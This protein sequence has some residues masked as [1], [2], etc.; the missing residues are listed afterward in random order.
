MKLPSLRA[1][2]LILIGIAFLAGFGTIVLTQ[3]PLA[4]TKVTLGT[5]ASGTLTPSLF[6]IG[7]VEARRAYNIGPTVAGRVARVL[8]DQGDRVHAGQLLAEMD[9]VDLAE[10]QTAGAAAAARA[11]QL[12]AAA[13]AA[14]AEA[15]S[16]A[17]LAQASAARYA[18]LHARNFISKDAAA[19]KN[20]E[21][22]AATAA[23]AATKAALAAAESEARR[24][25]ADLAGTGRN[26]AL[27]RLLA[28]VDGVA[29]ARLAEP[30]STLVA[31]Q[32][33]LQMI[34]PASLWLRT[35]I[36][37][38]RSGGLAVGL[39]AEIHLRSRPGQPL[40]GHVERIEINGD[41]VTEE[42]IAQVAMDSP[43]ADPALGEIAEITL[44]LPVLANVLNIPAAAIKVEGGKTGVWI[45]DGGRTAFRAVD[46][47]S[48]T[49]QGQ[50]PVLDGLTAG[51][52]VI[53]YSAK[54]ILAGQRVKVVDS[55][56][57]GAP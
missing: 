40:T 12:A 15:A 10:R 7:T 18:E 6:G 46:V 32:A 19:A 37:Q 55:L 52:K 51:E 43:E 48:P 44:R 34:D 4:P 54:A 3:G 8:V 56:Q 35:R 24:A 11:E 23:H 31:G 39:P 16:R 17:K 13:A 36:D 38:G 47:G 30:G 41:A 29:S 50:V 21:A 33:V 9:P 20:H 57:A 49:S 45:I 42:R 14:V 5:V 25:R 27:L 53:V 1:T 22:T 2:I 26:R 28:P